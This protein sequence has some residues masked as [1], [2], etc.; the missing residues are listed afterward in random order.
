M[1]EYELELSFGID[2]GE[3][4]GLRLQDAF[5]LGY[6]FANFVEAMKFQP[7]GCSMVLHSGNWARVKAAAV[8]YNRR[9]TSSWCEQDASE[10]WMQLQIW[11]TDLPAQGPSDAM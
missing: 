1:N 9:V 11:P 6:E 2:H 4:D 10:D 3:L 8:K 7:A 5:V